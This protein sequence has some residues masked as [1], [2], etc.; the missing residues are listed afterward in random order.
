MWKGVES[1]RILDDMYFFPF[2]EI[3]YGYWWL[4]SIHR[5][6]AV[7]K[8]TNQHKISIYRMALHNFSC[9]IVYDKVI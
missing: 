1:N 6:W 9:F 5:N 7:V 3:K 8:F 2:M 4:S